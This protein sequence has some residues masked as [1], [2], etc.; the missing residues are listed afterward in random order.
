MWNFYLFRLFFSVA[1]EVLVFFF[2]VLQGHCGRFR[3]IIVDRF[4]GDVSGA[5]GFTVLLFSCSF[6]GC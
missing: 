5:T 2:Y 4:T 1:H 3:V 6:S